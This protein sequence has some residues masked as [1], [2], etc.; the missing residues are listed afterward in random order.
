[1]SEGSA[2][3]R[4]LR[5]LA[6]RGGDMCEAALSLAA[7]SV[8]R[9]RLSA[10]TASQLSGYTASELRDITLTK[11]SAVDPAVLVSVVVPA[12]NEE[13]N[14]DALWKRLRPVLDAV[15]GGELV[16]VDDGSD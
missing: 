5:D 15:G 14:L 12:F 16:I 10:E 11:P 1:M 13:T 9:G 6:D 8:L 2:E 3:Q 7:G 4:V